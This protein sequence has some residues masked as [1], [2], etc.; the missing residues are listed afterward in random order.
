VYL[1]PI[2]DVMM[3]SLPVYINPRLLAV[4]E[5]R[6]SGGLKLSAMPRLCRL[7]TS[8]EGT[9]QCDLGFKM[10][11]RL[12]VMQAHLQAELWLSCERCCESVKYLLDRSVQFA[13][14]STEEQVQ[15]IP[16]GMEAVVLTDAES[17]LPILLEDEALLSLPMVPK[18]NLSD[19]KG[20][21]NDILQKSQSSQDEPET[22]KP[23]P[24]AI[25]SQL[26]SQE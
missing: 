24:F 26:K 18:H 15:S 17:S 21:V 16:A 2:D 12:P 7:L 10:E 13:F 23:N 9:L 4:S 14:V 8:S 20:V 1:I 25:L 22:E 11:G 5:Q 6:L 19:C 3:K